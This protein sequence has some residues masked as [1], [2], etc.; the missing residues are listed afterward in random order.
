MRP[1]RFFVVMFA[2]LVVL[3]WL[4]GASAA[5]TVNTVFAFDGTDGQFPD[6]GVLTQGRDGQ[7]YGTT[8]AGGTFGL[9][10]VFRQNLDGTNTVLYNFSG[11][12]G[13]APDEGLTL[14]RDGNFYGTTEAGG[15]LNN[16]V[17]FRITTSGVVTVL[18]NFTGGTGGTFPTSPPIEATDGNL[19]GTTAGV[20]GQYS[21][22]YRY[23]PSGAFSTVLSF[24]ASKSRSILAFAPPMQAA[25]GD[26]Y[27]TTVAGGA[28]DCGSLVRLA[29][30]GV[31]ESTHSFSCTEGGKY[32]SGP[33]LQAAD[34]N[35]Y[36]T[37]E[38]GGVYGQGTLYDLD[39]GGVVTV[40]YSLGTLPD[41]GYAAN[42][43]LTQGTDGNFYGTASGGGSLGYGTIYQLTSADGYTQLYSFPAGGSPTPAPM[44]HTSG[45]FYGTARQCCGL[46]LGTI[47]SLDMS[48]GPFITFVRPSGKVGQTAQILGQ[49]LTGTTSVTFNGVAAAT[50]SV[51]SDTYMTAVVPSGATT[52]A[53]VVTTPGGALTSNVSF[54]ISK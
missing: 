13:N 27:A 28:F 36:G 11:P 8:F 1:A 43:G 49:G 30:S 12:D 37:T 9:G 16:G 53:V 17:L 2:L 26:L 22:L 45:L 31:V 47:Y 35:I 42:S 46:G 3:L 39:Q 23:T 52:G 15:T 25:N 44:Q 14:G 19:Y 20:S 51:V 34:G 21:T 40:L 29:T 32:P 18:H 24:P 38:E 50:F 54:R 4:S 6:W 41:D 5:Q 7:L 10:V 33:L 48:L